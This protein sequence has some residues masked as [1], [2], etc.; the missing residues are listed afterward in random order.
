MDTSNGMQ[1]T[2]SYWVKTNVNLGILRGI[3]TFV[4]DMK[5]VA[6]MSV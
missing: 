5:P 3:S 1:Q 2:H 4:C 6:S